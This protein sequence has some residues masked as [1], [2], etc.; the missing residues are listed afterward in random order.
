MRSGSPTRSHAAGVGSRGRRGLWFRVGSASVLALLVVVGSA[1]PVLAGGLFKA[2]FHGKLTLTQRICNPPNPAVA[3]A[4][5]ASVDF[6][7][8]GG[9][10][11]ANPNPLG[12]GCRAM[13]NPDPGKKDKPGFI[14]FPAPSPLGGSNCKVDIFG[15]LGKG[16]TDPVG[17]KCGDAEGA[18]TGSVAIL[19]PG[20][21][22]VKVVTVPPG[23]PGTVR[24]VGAKWRFDGTAVKGGQSG[25]VRLEWTAIEDPDKPGHRCAEP[26]GA[27][28]F[29]VQDG[30]WVTKLFGSKFGNQNPFVSVPAGGPLAVLT[31]AALMLGGAAFALASS[32]R[33]AGG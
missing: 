8:H 7:F 28:E 30:L 12:T 17:P 13:W 15:V 24:V 1:Q 11:N 3:C 25:P 33:R 9:L 21:A 5:H 18:W 6:E 10:K 14:P 23:S 20:N 22:T 16:V 27:S 29:H 4:K 32:R 26:P 2:A 19:G 31:L